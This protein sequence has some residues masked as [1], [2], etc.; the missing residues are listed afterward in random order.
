MSWHI[1]SARDPRVISASQGT[2]II[3]D[4]CAALGINPAGFI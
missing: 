1:D 2:T 3:V 4:G